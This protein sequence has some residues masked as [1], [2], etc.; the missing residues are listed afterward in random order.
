MIKENQLYNFHIELN[1]LNKLLHLSILIIF[2]VVKM[3]IYIVPWHSIWIYVLH[4][5]DIQDLRQVFNDSRTCYCLVGLYV[6]PSLEGLYSDF[7]KLFHTWNNLWRDSN[8]QRWGICGAV[9]NI[10]QVW[11]LNQTNIKIWCSSC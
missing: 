8:L 7:R 5:L 10:C 9:L 3:Q 1:F 11:Y 6:A 4:V 2:V